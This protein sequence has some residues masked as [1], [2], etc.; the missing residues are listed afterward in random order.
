MESAKIEKRLGVKELAAYG[1]GN[2]IGSGIFV[3]MGTGI[4][5][6]GT[7]IILALIVANILVLFAYAYKTLMSGMFELS[8]G[9]YSQAALLQPPI[10]VGVSAMSNLFSG[11]AFAMYAISFVEYAS[12]V[13]PGLAE[14]EKLI[15]IAVITVF[16]LSTLKGSSFMGKLNFIMVAILII[17]LLVYIAVG[18]PQVDYS[19][20]LPGDGYFSDGA[21]GFIMAVAMM[22]FACQGATLPVEMTA[23][24]KEPKKSL[25][26]AILLA[27]LV[28]TVVYVLISIVSVGVVPAEAVAGRNLGVVALEIFPY[29]V[30]V[31]FILG[32]ACFAI[33]TSLYGAIASRPHPMMA[34]IREGWLPKWLGNTTK[35]GYPYAM[36]VVFY[37][38]AIIPIFIDLGLNTLISLMMIPIMI[39]NMLNNILMFPL[40]KK[41]PGAWK[42]GFFSIPLWLLKVVIT[43]AILADLLISVA[44]FTTLEGMERVFM[45]VIVILL[46]AYSHYRI[47]K[48]YVN[49]SDIEKVKREAEETISSSC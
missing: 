42:S 34:T 4:G 26:K 29:P 1:I 13:F 11:L 18:L 23:D 2:C 46:F 15:A 19:S 9:A 6:T 28:V 43:L 45:V 21:M 25:P 39:L 10:L 41:Y 3:S 36:M 38:V 44:L 32:G 5:Y 24:A 31:I 22:A 30:F 35:S 20:I 16:F 49:L 7:S 47:K 27:S 37:I 40:V 48:G 14:F 12:T 8:G 33:L 17:S